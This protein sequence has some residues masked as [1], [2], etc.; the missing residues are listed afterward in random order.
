M[1]ALAHRN[2][3][4]GIGTYLKHRCGGHASGVRSPWHGAVTAAARLRPVRMARQGLKCGC[5]CVIYSVNG[6]DHGEAGPGG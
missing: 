2:D 4:S 6:S 3:I 5:Q 1:P